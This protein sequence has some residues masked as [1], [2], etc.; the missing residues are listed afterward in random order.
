MHPPSRRHGSLGRVRHPATWGFGGGGA[1]RAGSRA[2]RPVHNRPDL[3][4]G[5]VFRRPGARARKTPEAWEAG[6]WD[7]RGPEACGCVGLRGAGNVLAMGGTGTRGLD[8]WRAGRALG[9]AAPGCRFRRLCTRPPASTASSGAPGIRRP[10]ALAGA[11][12]PGPARGRAGRCITAPICG[13][14]R[15]FGGRG[16]GRDGVGRLGG[17]LDV[18]GSTSQALGAPRRRAGRGACPARRRGRGCRPVAGAGMR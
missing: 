2:R 18:R 8:E 5:A 15:F 17:A 14:R 10:G 6:T 7:A 11:G 9:K 3:R 1:P 4:T 16:A 13:R 12:R